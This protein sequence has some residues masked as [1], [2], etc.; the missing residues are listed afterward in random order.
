MYRSFRDDQ[1]VLFLDSNGVTFFRQ[2]IRSVRV[3]LREVLNVLQYHEVIKRNAWKW[4]YHGIN[5]RIH[6]LPSVI[7]YE[8]RMRKQ[9]CKVLNILYCQ[10]SKY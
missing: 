10:S 1:T 5:S 2:C 7:L 9:I 6:S 3:P 8:F 4:N